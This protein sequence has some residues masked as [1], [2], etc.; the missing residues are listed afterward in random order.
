M[1]TRKAED[2]PDIP[3]AP[4]I[5]DAPS[6]EGWHTDLARVKFEAFLGKVITVLEVDWRDSTFKNTDESR[7][8]P[9]YALLRVQCP[10]SV[11]GVRVDDDQ[12]EEPVIVPAGE[13]VTTSTGRIRICEQIKRAE[14]SDKGLPVKGEV[15][16]AGQTAGGYDI[17]ELRA[18]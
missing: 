3:D 15:V 8:K 17:W 2:V 14:D 9:Q 18:V 16:I 6:G 5:A 7:P 11:P 1:A 13:E 4:S 10:S 12:N